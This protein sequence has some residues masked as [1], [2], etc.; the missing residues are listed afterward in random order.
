M[1]GSTAMSS[2]WLHLR[3]EGVPVFARARES[4]LRFELIIKMDLVHGYVLVG[5][6]CSGVQA[7]HVKLKPQDVPTH[8]HAPRYTTTNTKMYENGRKELQCQELVLQ[9]QSSKL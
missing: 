4:H 8:H 3:W 2:T 1:G 5:L 7:T 6:G 9:H